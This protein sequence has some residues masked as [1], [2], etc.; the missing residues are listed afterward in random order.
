MIRNILKKTRKITLLANTSGMIPRK[1]VV[2]PTITE[3][4]ISPRALAM[5]VSLSTLGS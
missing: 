5:R 1:V 3:G 4:P 2:A